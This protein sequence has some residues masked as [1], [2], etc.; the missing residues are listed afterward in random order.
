[1]NNINVPIKNTMTGTML[2]NIVIDT[3][4]KN[5]HA[6]GNVNGVLQLNGNLEKNT[7]I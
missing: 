6:I 1:M 5:A 4:V 3:A 7:N 2:V